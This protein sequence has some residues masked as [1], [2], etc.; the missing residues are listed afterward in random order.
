MEETEANTFYGEA[1]D[2]LQNDGWSIRLREFSKSFSIQVEH[3]LSP[4]F[5]LSFDRSKQNRPLFE[6]FMR[7]PEFAVIR[8]RP[9][10]VSHPDLIKSLRGASSTLNWPDSVL[11]T[12]CSILESFE[13]I[14][15]KEAEWLAEFGGINWTLEKPSP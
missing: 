14:T 2:R 13:I 10:T 11:P 8:S 5:S 3:P 7:A 6:A 1:V 12:L 15:S 9:R 4:M